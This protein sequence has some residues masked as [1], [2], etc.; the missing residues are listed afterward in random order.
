MLRLG[1]NGMPRQNLRSVAGQFVP[2]RAGFSASD[3]RGQKR[4]TPAEAGVARKGAIAG[5]AE[6]MTRFGSSTERGLCPEDGGYPVTVA[7]RATGCE[8]GAAGAVTGATA[9]ALRA[10]SAVIRAASFCG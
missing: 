7:G 8:G 10:S 2:R 9:G 5:Q 4:K 6:I 3:F 1:K